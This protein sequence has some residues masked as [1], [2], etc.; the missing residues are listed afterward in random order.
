MSGDL[1]QTQV[2]LPSGRAGSGRGWKEAEPDHHALPLQPAGI[3]PLCWWG[4]REQLPLP[5][6]KSAGAAVRGS[7]ISAA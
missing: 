4:P 7:L 2:H 1:A 6:E 5:S 3:S